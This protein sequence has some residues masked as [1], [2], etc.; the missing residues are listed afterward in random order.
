[1]TSSKV[2]LNNE[3]GRL[4]SNNDN[5]VPTANVVLSFSRDALLDYFSYGT[6]SS[7]SSKE[8]VYLF[9]P[10]DGLFLDF[11]HQVNAGSEGGMFSLTLLDPLGEFLTALFSYTFEDA[12]KEIYAR[13][14]GLSNETP[15]KN[16]PEVMTVGPT[17]KAN[18]TY[19]Q[20]QEIL[21]KYSQTKLYLAY[22]LGTETR[23]WAGPFIVNISNAFYNEG[24]DSANKLELQFVGTDIVGDPA[25]ATTSDG[26]SREVFSVD[27]LVAYA[28]VTT[29]SETLE[30]ARENE[31]A[32]QTA[33]RDLQAAASFLT[34]YFF[35]DDPVPPARTAFNIAAQDVA[36]V[37]KKRN[38]VVHLRYELEHKE[39]PLEKPLYNLIRKYL[40]RLGYANC[41]VLMES[42][43]QKFE[44]ENEQ[45]EIKKTTKSKTTMYSDIDMARE[46]LVNDLF[47]SLGLE[48]GESRD[49]KAL[50]KEAQISS[51]EMPI[52]SGKEVK[53]A[54]KKYYLKLSNDVKS[55][56]PDS[57]FYPIIRLLQNF[58]TVTQTGF[59]NRVT[60][61]NNVDKVA[62]L[63]QYFP[64]LVPDP[65]SPVV[66]I[67][68][69]RLI[70]A[71][72]YAKVDK[73]SLNLRL[74]GPGC[75]LTYVHEKAT[76]G[77]YK[78][79]REVITRKKSAFA[80]FDF[81]DRGRVPDDFSISL[82][83]QKSIA[84]FGI[85]VFRANT[86]NPNVL[87]FT[88]QNQG[89][90]LST[91]SDTIQQIIYFLLD[92]SN[93]NEDFLKREDIKN[94]VE[95]LFKDRERISS[96]ANNLGIKLTD[97]DQLTDNL[98]NHLTDPAFIGLTYVSESSPAVVLASYMDNFYKMF[99][100]PYKAS[101]KT[102]PYY[103]LS[104]IDLINDFCLFFKN[105]HDV[106]MMEGSDNVNS[107]YSGFWRFI[108]FKHVIGESDAYSEFILIKDATTSNVFA[109]NLGK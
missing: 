22:G 79:M 104:E 95:D 100:K 41:I 108:G 49:P 13:K 101:I 83:D 51:E 66:I 56:A 28:T 29:T 23:N 59:V 5:L 6:K 26:E 10:E 50:I 24:L 9:K 4:R 8:S 15:V 98:Y 30:Q 21:A 74:G 70:Q 88:T 20:R 68:D 2:S 85:P 72:L 27:E 36:A 76:P 19:E 60:I 93:T 1:M 54:R 63:N 43:G 107:I 38:A 18:F 42:L 48:I 90:L 62:L 37:N 39:D 31:P 87:S 78:S 7:G 80:F 75:D 57:K 32:I 97:Q 67:G 96:I 47:K 33:A 106:E 25:L 89:I 109:K 81:R 52:N 71:I 69:D 102:L 16:T 105:K 12:L 73:S 65:T 61:E 103:N 94:Y 17:K 34:S 11:V 92:S 99:S 35:S 45:D 14:N 64:K 3:T 58:K 91:Y 55:Q 53:K 77:Y 86:E 82:Q 40:K 44:F 84:E 46:S